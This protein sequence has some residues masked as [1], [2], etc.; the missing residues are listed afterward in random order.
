MAE[1][2]QVDTHLCIIRDTITDRAK[3]D[4]LVSDA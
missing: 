3:Y 4:K 2:V 1:Q